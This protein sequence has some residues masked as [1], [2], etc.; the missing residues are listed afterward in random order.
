MV[1]NC[2]VFS[3]R[4]GEVGTVFAD[5]EVTHAVA[6][7]D[8]DGYYN[9]NV[10]S[11][12]RYKIENGE[13]SVYKMNDN[14]TSTAQN[15]LVIPHK[16]SNAG[17]VYNVRN[18]GHRSFSY[19]RNMENVT[20]PNSVTN[21]ESYAFDSCSGL[22]HINIPGSV[23][24]IG[25]KAFYECGGLTDIVVDSN[26]TKYDS[27]NN[28]NAIIETATNKL[29]FGCQNTVIPDT[30]S[31]IADCAFA[32]C[33]GLT[34]ITIP[35]S[36]TSIGESAFYN[37][38]GL[39]GTIT[40]PDSVTSLGQYAFAGCS[41]L[42]GLRIS[43]N[44]TSIGEWTFG[45]CSGLI[46]TIILPSGLANI[47]DYAFYNC[48]NLNGILNIPSSV[49]SIGEMC[50]QYCVNLIGIV[51]NPNNDT[52][53]SRNNC[54]CLI[55]TETN[56]LLFG[57]KNS[58]IPSDITSVSESAF[59]ECA[60]L[61]QIT[62]PDSVTS[63]GYNAFYGCG[64]EYLEIPNSVTDIGCYAFG[65][66]NN[67]KT[68]I[69]GVNWINFEVDDASS[70]IL[71]YSENLTNIYVGSIAQEHEDLN[72]YDGNDD[73]MEFYAVTINSSGTVS[74]EMD[75]GNKKVYTTLVEGKHLVRKEAVDNGDVYVVTLNSDTALASSTNNLLWT[76]KGNSGE[77]AKTAYKVVVDGG[78]YG[79]L[80]QGANGETIVWRNASQNKI[81]STTVVDLS[82]NQTLNGEVPTFPNTGVGVDIILPSAM[83]LALS[84]AICI[85]AFGGKK[86]KVIIK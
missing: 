65:G 84:V 86:R 76:K 60:G 75:G 1:L 40:I 51:V 53:D 6:N 34:S 74:Y 23:V 70:A 15:P 41:G 27:R 54:N 49:N 61:T 28:C 19:E 25:E 80:P 85:V 24:N 77:D 64:F 48:R 9:D 56:T 16:I 31:V 35:S 32:N 46:G 82:A 50:F 11:R 81:K 62:I 55:E 29:I 14:I 12:L 3:S 26:N 83:I 44:I 57:C 7:A 45:N 36:V 39:T 5:A 21:I 43:S 58:N 38:S 63:I 20:I 8:G 67:L 47:G 10:D 37:C 73:P 68:V 4:I 22:L 13:A 59:E 69:I 78:L 66:N 33:S 72:I 2:S 17:N 71:S 52:Y 79:P 42:T 18:V 30:I